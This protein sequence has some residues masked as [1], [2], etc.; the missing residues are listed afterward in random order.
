MNSFENTEQDQNSAT[1]TKQ[2][3]SQDRDLAKRYVFKWR[4]KAD[5]VKALEAALSALCVTD[6]AGVHSRLQPKL[7]RKNG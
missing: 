3:G 6:R 5:I 4:L 2:C 1:W 7:A